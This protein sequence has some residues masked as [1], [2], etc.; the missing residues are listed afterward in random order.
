MTK[1]S[2]K[3]APEQREAVIVTAAVNV[4]NEDG[5]SQISLK[6]VASKCK[7]KTSVR[8][9]QSYYT[10]DALRKIVLAD[11]RTSQEARDEATGMGIVL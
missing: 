10:M 9:V 3:L 5:F 8:T 11:T 2:P 1:N 7:P 4:A 6:T